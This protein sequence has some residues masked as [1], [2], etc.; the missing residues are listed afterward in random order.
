MRVREPDRPG[1]DFPSNGCTPGGNSFVNVGAVNPNTVCLTDAQL[2]GELSTMIQQTGLLGRTQPGYTPLVTLLMPPGV[3]TCLDPGNEICSANGSLTPPPPVVTTASTGG[4]IPAGTYRVVV[5]YATKTGE[6]LVSGPQSVS[7]TGTT[8]SITIASPPAASGATGWYAYIAASDG[9]T[10]ARQK[11]VNT[12]GSPL[13]LTALT[14]GGAAP[15]YTTT[16]CSYHSQVKVGTTEVAYVVQPWTALT[17]CD[18]PDAPAIDANPGPQELAR[19]AGIRLVS[20]LSQSHIAAIVNPQLNAWSALDGSEIDD[21]FGC[22][23]SLAAVAVGNSAQNPYLLQAEFN[24]AGVIESEP[25]TYFGCAPG[26]ILS[27]HFVVPSSINLGDTV[28]FDGS[29]TASTLLVPNSGYSW[30]FGDNTY[31][32]GPSVVHTYA[33]AGT[34]T[35]TLRVT[36]RGGNAATLT[37]TVEVLDSTGQPVSPGKG[38]SPGLHVHIQLM[39]QGLRSVLRAGLA[40]RL[41]SNE[42]ADAIATLSISRHA[43]SRAHIKHGRRATVVIGRGSV[44][45]IKDGTV[46]LHLRLPR[47]VASKLRHLRHVTVS[48][49]LMLFASGGEHIALDAAGRY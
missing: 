7:T 15:T 34:Y 18:Q 16:F 19:D 38:P 8:S 31:A 44:R 20:S 3:E 24:N 17:G 12:I 32:T 46:K 41:T 2:Q 39:P 5:T 47:S 23:N 42:S 29:T 30:S 37:Q 49:R 45:G 48:V 35:V 28:Q 40:L 6:S 43:A 25:N 13:T 26:V 4:S 27:P 10:Y 21:N 22:G 33:K 11:S 1:H 36:D 9:T 14:S